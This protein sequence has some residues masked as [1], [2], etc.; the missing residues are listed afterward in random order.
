MIE[1]RAMLVKNKKF[2]GGFSLA[3][4]TIIYVREVQDDL[5]IAMYYETKGTG[6]GF[7]LENDDFSILEA[8]DIR[9]AE[10]I[11]IPDPPELS[12]D[13]HARQE[14]ERKR[15]RSRIQRHRE[16]AD[17]LERLLP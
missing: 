12:E 7:H 9:A 3:S 6:H 15:I 16:E 5:W 1:M 13:F 17:R 14:L 8:G 10:L 4:G 11:V 2:E